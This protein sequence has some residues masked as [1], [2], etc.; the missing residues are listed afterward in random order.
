VAKAVHESDAL[1]LRR[2]E[3]GEADLVLTLFT[4]SLGRISALARGAR[5]SRRRFGG[6]LE[7]FFTLSVRME[8]RPT[9]EL[10]TLLDASVVRARLGLLEDLARIDAAGRALAWVR[11]AAPP[12]TPEPEA[13]GLLERLLERLSAANPSL[14]ADRELAEVGLPLL[15]S[16]GWGIEFDRCVRCGKACPTASAA[17]L[18]PL[19]G[20]LVCR[21][22]GGG[23]VHLS[24]ERR[25]RLTRAAS[26]VIGALEPDDVKTAL[27]LVERVFAAHAGIE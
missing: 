7:P 3:L 18:D 26:G 9:S 12:R 27:S 4:R 14:S 5:K 6:A 20:G 19:R 15:T 23:T 2:V 8:E 13:F 1:V 25:Q 10:F 16:F 11:K 17:G 22:C 21:D 24:A